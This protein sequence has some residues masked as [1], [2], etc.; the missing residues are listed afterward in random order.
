MMPSW[1]VHQKWAERYLQWGS[2]TYPSED[3][4]DLINFPEER[5]FVLPK[6]DFNRR[7]WRNNENRSMIQNLFGDVGLQIMDLHYCLDFL[8]EETSS[9]II[10]QKWTMMYP[11][12]KDTLDFPYP[13]TIDLARRLAGK[14]KDLNLEMKVFKFVIVNFREI[15]RDIISEHEY[16][17]EK[18]KKWKSDSFN[19][20]LKE[21]VAI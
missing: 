1:K 18:L 20:I 5:D 16:S 6:H 14:T 4:A 11:I 19:R 21:L 2:T 3:I 8:K 15:L 17:P 12:V 13:S 7:T 9:E 10:E